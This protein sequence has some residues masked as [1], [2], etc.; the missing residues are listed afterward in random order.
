MPT[1]RAANARGFP[2]LVSDWSTWCSSYGAGSERPPVP[3]QSC[4]GRGLRF[5][6]DALMVLYC[7]HQA[8]RDCGVVRASAPDG[9]AVGQRSARKNRV[10]GRSQRPSRHTG[11]FAQSFFGLQKAFW[12]PSS[13][14]GVAHGMALLTWAVLALLSLGSVSVRDSLEEITDEASQHGAIRAGLP[15]IAPNLPGCGGSGEDT[16]FRRYTGYR[17]AD[18][19]T[20][21]SVRWGLGGEQFYFRWLPGLVSQPDADPR[22]LPVLL[23]SLPAL[24]ALP[25]LLPPLVEAVADA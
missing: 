4:A 15:V 3:F 12:Y 19:L 10:R 17:M 20:K 2:T 24:L 5:E 21:G 18:M 16:S 23:L 22:A 6:F 9:I 13:G 7:C 11:R 8:V 25:A 14:P 1:F